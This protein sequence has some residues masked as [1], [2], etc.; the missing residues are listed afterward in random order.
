[1]TDEQKSTIY[2][3]IDKTIADEI[4]W[5][6]ETQYIIGSDKDG[7]TY[8][9]QPYIDMSENDSPKKIIK[10]LKS[11]VH[12]P[13]S[14]QINIFGDK[15][16]LI[17]MAS[18]QCKVEETDTRELAEENPDNNQELPPVIKE[19]IDPHDKELFDRLTSEALRSMV[20]SNQQ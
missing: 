9:L 14:P 5:K 10:E 7:I 6:R 3:I 2:Q 20:R 17:I 15:G 11:I 16:D 19:I 4:S 8:C 13:P 12:N 1:M 18:M